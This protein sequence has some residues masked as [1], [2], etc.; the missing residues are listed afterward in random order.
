MRTHRTT[1]PH[2]LGAAAAVLTAAGT[3][4]LASPADAHADRAATTIRSI[5]TSGKC[6]EVA[7]WRTDDGAPVRQWSCHGGANQQWITTDHG[8][9][10]NVH[11]GKCLDIPNYSP[12]PGTQAVQWTCNRGLNQAWHIH[13]RGWKPE[14]YVDNLFSQLSLDLFGWGSADGT[15][16]GQWTPHGEGNQRWYL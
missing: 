9:I 4:V 13:P 8:E 6:L 11:S 2:R 14:F 16:V 3:L 15:P 1:A 10:V 5:V 12:T 7:D